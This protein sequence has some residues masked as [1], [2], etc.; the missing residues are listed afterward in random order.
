MPHTAKAKDGSV[1]PRVFM[2]DLWAT[3]PYY[4]AYLSRALLAAGV[5]VQIGSITY[6]LDR[7]C[8]HARGLRLQP[9]C[10]DLVGKLNLPR[11]AR[12]V[13]KLLE[14]GLNL[15]AL[16]L[17]FAFS[18][19]E[20]V[21]VQFLPLLRSRLPLDLWF[22]RFCRKRGSRL[23]LTVHDLLP[24][25]TGQEHMAVY[26]GLYAEMDGLICHSAHIR[27]RLMEEFGVPE[28]KISVIPHGP[29]FYD[30]PLGNLGEAT[31]LLG[32]PAGQ[33]VVLWQGIIFPYK[34]VD[35]LLKAWEIVEA[36][37]HDVTLVVLGTGDPVLLNQ[38]EQQARELGLR[39]VQFHFRFCSTAELVSAYRAATVVVYPYRAITTSG[40]L[41]T[42]LALGKAIV[43]SD[44]P[45]FQELLIHEE[46]GLLVDPQAPDALAAALLRAAQD[47]ELRERLSRKVAAMRFGDQSWAE[48]ARS[49]L[50]V[51]QR[52]MGQPEVQAA[53]E[54]SPRSL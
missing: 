31:E 2:M 5:R 1:G 15:L 33:R 17:R 24:H 28:A 10:S 9:G 3:V 48:I 26:V 42:G 44:L 22:A 13:L 34:G 18:P 21:H 45:V 51:Y 43:A 7:D 50:T 20:I 8:F 27:S 30:L 47:P 41:A 4:T 49:T 54:A 53:D 19:P 16:G 6:Y 46:N 14:G 39:R 12:R 36:T 37:S 25:D 35:L 32:V 40:A 29:F 52:V 23:I 11:L 38:L